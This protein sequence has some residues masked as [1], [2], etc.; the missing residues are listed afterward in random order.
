[1]GREDSHY[2]PEGVDGRKSGGP[3][4]GGAAGRVRVPGTNPG[5]DH[6]GR[7]QPPG[8]GTDPAG[9]A[10][11]YAAVP[12]APVSWPGADTSAGIPVSPPVPPAGAAPPPPPYPRRSR[13]RLLGVL[14]AVLVI[15][16]AGAGLAVLRPG[17]LAGWL[18]GSAAPTAGGRTAEPA[19]AEVLAGA[20]P[21]AAT[22][23]PD[24]VRAALEP[25]IGAAALGERVNVS[26]ADV[27]TG[28]AL[29]GRGQDTPTVP[30]SVTK[31][32]T[33][34]AVLAARGPAYRI[35]TRAVAGPNPGEVVLV[36]GGDPTLAVDKNGFYPGAARLDDLAGQVRTALGGQAPTKVIVDSSLFS[37]QVYGP[38]WDDDIPTGGF[39]AAI[40][41]LTTDGARRDPEAARKTFDDAHGAAERVPQPD[42]TAGRQFAKLLGLSGDAAGV[43]RGSAPT[44]SGGAAPAPGAELGRVESLPMVRLVDIMISDS[45]NVIAEYLARQ[46]ALAKGKPASFAGGA[47]ATDEVLGEL[48]LPAG[49]IDLA[50]GSGLSRTNRIS[51]SLLTDLITLAGNGSH[52]ELAAIFGGLPVGGWSGTLG[53]RYQESAT[54]AGAGVVRAK[55]GTLTGVNAIAGL[56]TTADGRLLTFA[57][58]T[59]RAPA[60]TLDATREALDRI[61]SALAG[62]GC[63]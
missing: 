59:D 19:P 11:P 55:T 20:D 50:D 41:A 1:M 12:P 33:G 47:A 36:G 51:P 10:D 7:A 5:S 8:Y 25:L 23:T 17:P 2:R 3:T 49:E 48:G 44:A 35:P 22:P 52:P 62:C 56:V 29:Y 28:T 26:V 18:G 16:V 45:D 46:V 39:G 9:R 32:A 4:A 15:V 58:L 37:G 30:A 43:K 40:T 42:L 31:L 21:N 38:G 6:V 24:G 61:S 27:A 63:R 14:A 60:G 34:V 53:D 13:G 57:V 54:R